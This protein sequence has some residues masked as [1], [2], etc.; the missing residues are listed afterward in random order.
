[1][2]RRILP[3]RNLL[4]RVQIHHHHVDQTDGML[5]QRRHMLAVGAN[6]Q[7]SR[8]HA[9]MDGLHAPVQHLRKPCQLRDV[10]HRKTGLPDRCRGAAGRNQLDPQPAQPARKFHYTRL[11]GNAQQRSLNFWHEPSILNGPAIIG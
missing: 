11:V 3:R 5:L 6:R 10:F 2:H 1:M 7:H 4:E 8:R 9:R